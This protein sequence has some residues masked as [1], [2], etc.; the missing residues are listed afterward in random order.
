VGTLQ[1][2]LQFHPRACLLGRALDHFSVFEKVIG[3][4]YANRGLKL[5]AEV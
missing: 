3:G 2:R 4:T 5:S 1:T